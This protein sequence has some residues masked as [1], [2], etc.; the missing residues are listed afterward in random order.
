MRKSRDLQ[1]Q[2]REFKEKR[3]QNREGRFGFTKA[4]MVLMLSPSPIGGLHVLNAIAGICS[5]K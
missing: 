4:A 5:E 2:K 3:E 1:S